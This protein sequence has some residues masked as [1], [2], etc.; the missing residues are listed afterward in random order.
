VCRFRNAHTVEGYQ[1][2]A[3][4]LRAVAGIRELSANIVRGTLTVHGTADQLRWPAGCLTNWINLL[5]A[6]GLEH[7][8]SS[9]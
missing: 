3:T 1:E 8:L 7:A 4:V 2:I 9:G 5:P 6:G